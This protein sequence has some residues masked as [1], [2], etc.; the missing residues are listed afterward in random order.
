M[1]INA[2]AKKE[3]IAKHKASN[4]DTGSAEVQI[5]L[6]TER[7]ANL[8]DH[9]KAHRKDFHSTRGLMI[10]VGK[11]KRMLAYLKN[12]DEKRFLAIVE[13]LGLKKKI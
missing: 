6:F 3:I 5:A 9:L 13:Q 10:L 11:R 12:K 1:S 8:T 7:I 4:N 2:E